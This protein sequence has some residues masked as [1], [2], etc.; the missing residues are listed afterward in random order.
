MKKNSQLRFTNQSFFIG[1]DV[2]KRNKK[3]RK[4]IPD[5]APAVPRGRNLYHCK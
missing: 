2:H 4:L 5:F 3:A 1:I